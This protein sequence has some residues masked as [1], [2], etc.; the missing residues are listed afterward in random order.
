MLTST[1]NP[2]VKAIRKLHQAKFRSA[3]QQFLLEGTH[4]VQAALQVSYPIAIG[5]YTPAWAAR[6]PDLVDG[7]NQAADRVEVVAD[8]VLQAVATTVHPDGVVAVAARRSSPAPAVTSL[9]LV[10]ETLQDP[11]NLGTIIRTGVAA[12]VNGLWLSQDSVAPDHPKVLRASAGQWFHLPMTVSTDLVETVRPWR[13]RGLQVVATAAAA[14]LDYWAVDFTQPTILL[15]G[16][17][18]AGLSPAL[19]DLATVTASIPMEKAVE[20]LNVGIATALLVYEANRQRRHSL[21]G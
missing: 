14:P 1:Q 4:L 11:G 3:Q 6:Y 15:L 12:G 10:L 19:Q 18:G 17:E 2:L 16:N 20:S 21:G 13:Q 7:L 8:E 9:G 5:C